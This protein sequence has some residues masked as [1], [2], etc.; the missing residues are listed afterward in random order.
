MNCISNRK[1]K[2]ILVVLC[3]FLVELCGIIVTNYYT[4]AHKENTKLLKVRHT[5]KT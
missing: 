5:N 2:K 4:K 1:A 3:V